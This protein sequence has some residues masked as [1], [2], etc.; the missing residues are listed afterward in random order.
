MVSSKTASQIAEISMNILM[1]ESLGIEHL[2][3]A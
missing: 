2:C 1:V 3:E